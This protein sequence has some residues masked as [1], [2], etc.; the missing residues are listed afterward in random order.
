MHDY[1][2]EEVSLA[3]IREFVETHHYSKSVRGITPSYCFRIM[4][5]EKVFGAAIFGRPAMKETIDRY[6]ENGTVNMVE[7]RRFVMIDEAPRNSESRC[8]AMMFR[9][10]RKKGVERI[11]SYADPNH[12]HVGTIYKAV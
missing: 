4:F 3:D 5:A 7:L 12:G 8:L 1:L 2:I 6:S 9:T 10:L 11:L